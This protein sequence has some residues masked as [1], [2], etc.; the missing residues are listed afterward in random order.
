MFFRKNLS[1]G[2]RVVAEPMQGYRSFSIC[3]WVLAG[4]IYENENERG[5]SHFI[6][7][8]LFKGT[9]SRSASVIASEMDSIGGN[10]NAFTAKECTCFY[11]KVLDDNM[12][13]AID[14]LSDIVYN[15]KFDAEDI[16]REHKVVC[17]EILMVE[18]NPEDLVHDGVVELLYRGDPLE[19]E[20]LG[21]QKSVCSF[22][23]DK[24]KDYMARQYI[25]ENMV[26][27]CAGNF[28]VEKL[29][30]LL[31]KYF[32]KNNGGVASEKIISKLTPGRA[33]KSTYKDIEQA[34]ICIGLPGYASDDDRK[35][36]LVL[37]NGIL[38][39]GMSSRLFQKIREERGLA[40]SVYSYPS[41][42][43]TTGY[44]ALYA[45]TTE[46]QSVQV[47][48][49]MLD[50]L[51]NIK[52]NGIGKDEFLR[53]KQQ[54]RGNYLLSRESTSSRANSI[55]KSELSTEKIYTEEEIIS[56]IESIT[57]DDVEKIIPQIIDF[58]NMSLMFVGKKSDKVAEL[59]KMILG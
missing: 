16:K 38:G 59:K 3:V 44:F 24:I 54:L 37:L 5:I 46:S 17:E 45:G 56:K 28:D 15:S 26:I 6:E 55:G 34:H 42:Y 12:E 23:K 11:A 50:E 49:L 30:T 40:Y 41:G 53:S 29:M 10:L 33:F 2:I 27:S 47:T 13:E 32:S 57:I 43:R 18:D 7:H 20:I 4:A 14:L 8:M 31:E 36:A 52:S 21:T 1:N 39:G 22:D 35:Y 51:K 48:Q 25:A 19:R 9:E 58:D